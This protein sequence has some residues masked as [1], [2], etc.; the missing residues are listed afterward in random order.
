MTEYT[1]TMLL[2]AVTKW[3]LWPGNTEWDKLQKREAEIFVEGNVC[4]TIW[5]YI[6]VK[7]NDIQC[8]GNEC[9]KFQFGLILCHEN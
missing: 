2:F 7:G 8:N 1:E 9:R 6:S 4:T 5:L 3:H